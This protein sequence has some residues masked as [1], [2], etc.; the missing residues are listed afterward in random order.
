MKS[1]VKLY[2]Q[3]VSEQSDIVAESLGSS[4]LGGIL[5]LRYADSD[6][7][8]WF[9]GATKIALDKVQD[10]DIITMTPN[11]AYR[12][13]GRGIVFYV[14]TREKENPYAPYERGYTSVPTIPANT[15]LAI[16]SGDNKFYGTNYSKWINGGKTLSKDIKIT[17][18]DSG[19]GIGKS[20]RG[21]NATG[22]SSV[23]R[24]SE[25]SDV[26]YV[27]DLDALSGY[28][29]EDVRGTRREAKKGA[30]AFIT[31]KQ[32]RESN[33]AKYREILATRYDN[34]GVDREVQN[35]IDDATNML[36][37]GLRASTTDEYGTITIGKNKRGGEIRLN[38]LTN[39]MSNLLRDYSEYV[40][41]SNEVKNGSSYSEKYKKQ[42]ALSIR[43]YIDKFKKND[44]NW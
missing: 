37:K 3:F 38:D 30:A 8:K 2:E 9:Y 11:E 5:N 27:V 40:R 14:S 18:Y 22:L 33:M 1:Y 17:N 15:L 36:S 19:I 16:A 41:Y 34:D 4:I 24:I 35:A 39:W 29:T 12:W 21:W 26:A 23:K 10:S 44:I 7:F 42:Y 13:K 43:S 31:D 25:V 6:L 28:S 32:F 20:G